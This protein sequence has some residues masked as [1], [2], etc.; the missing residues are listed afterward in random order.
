MCRLKEEVNHETT[1]SLSHPFFMQECSIYKVAPSPLSVPVEHVHVGSPR[2]E[3]MS[4]SG[5][6][7]AT[8][9]AGVERPDVYEFIDGNH[10]VQIADHFIYWVTLLDWDFAELVL[11]PLEIAV[12]QG[13]EGRPL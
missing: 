1:S 6:Q 10:G 2:T 11:W 13:A 4:V 12:L 8:D 9:M 7:K 5:T 3:I